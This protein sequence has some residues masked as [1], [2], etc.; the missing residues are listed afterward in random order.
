MHH[1]TH[2]QV[3]ELDLRSTKLSVDGTDGLNMVVFHAEPGSRSAE[4][5]DILGSLGAPESG[6]AG[7]TGKQQRA[8]DP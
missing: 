7:R 4:L 6:R 5:L 3:G 1:L 8:E 2:P